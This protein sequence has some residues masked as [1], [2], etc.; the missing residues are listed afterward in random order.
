MQVSEE[1]KHLVIQGTP[2]GKRDSEVLSPP[3]STFTKKTKMADNQNPSAEWTTKFQTDLIALMRQQVF[4]PF[5]KELLDKVESLEK[6]VSKIPEIQVDVQT[7]IDNTNFNESETLKLDKR[8]CNL[9]KDNKFLNIRCNQLYEMVKHERKEKMEIKN[10]L[11]EVEDRQRRDNL[12]FEGVPDKKGESAGECRSSMRK[13][14]KDTLKVTDADN[15]SMGRVH[16]LGAYKEGENRQTIVKF[17]LFQQREKVWAKGKGLPTDTTTRIK[18][19]F[20]KE[21]EKARS[22]LYP[23]M[24]AARNKGY[25]AKLEGHKLIVRDTRDGKNLNVTCTMDNTSQLPPDLDPEKLFTPS[26]D[27]VTLYY[28]LFSPHSSFYECEFTHN[29]LTFNSLEQYIIRTNALTIQDNDL[30]ERV[31]GVQDPSVMK[32]M[33]KGKFDKIDLDIKQQ[34][35]KDGM[36]L[37]YG[38]N[39]RLK[40]L[41]KDTI[42]TT[43]AE[44]SPF[45]QTWGT[46]RRMTH[47]EAFKGWPGQNLHGKVLMEVRDEFAHEEDWD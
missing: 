46:G 36:K 14:L 1:N 30:A 22:K 3:N 9:E 20:S 11:S 29:G 45:D 19:N 13:H 27:G 12:V 40:S 43:L 16:R 6:E 34:H 39:E 17:D 5:K 4:D 10:K 2:V 33:A 32:S 28:T 44:A 38:Q 18:E 24:R 47:K 37:K 41:L 26:K 15:I 7:A 35:V 42:G 8:V 25:F 23:L 21:S 31:M